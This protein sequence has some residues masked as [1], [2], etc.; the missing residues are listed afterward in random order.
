MDASQEC[1]TSSNPNRMR[2]TSDHHKEIWGDAD[3]GIRCYRLF[4]EKG[5]NPLEGLFS[6]D[7]RAIEPAVVPRMERTEFGLL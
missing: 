6:N 4:P 2:R 5:H 1:S 3:R 7:E